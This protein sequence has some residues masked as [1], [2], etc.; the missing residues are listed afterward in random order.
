MAVSIDAYLAGMRRL[1]AGVT[2][3]TT[4]HEGIWA[5]LTATSVCALTAEPPRLLTCIQRDSDA[6]DLIA[7]SRRFVVNVL[8]TWHQDL[9]ERF[10]GRED[11]FGPERFA[12]GEWLEGRSGAPLL[13]GAAS[14]FECTLCEQVAASTHSIFIGEVEGVTL[15][16][17]E[18]LVYHERAYHRLVPIVPA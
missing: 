7:R 10:G 1:A 18:P 16:D 11:S 13:I 12:A 17:G 14:A 3:V 4:A 5:G 2:I 15:S 9:S 6:H 8:T